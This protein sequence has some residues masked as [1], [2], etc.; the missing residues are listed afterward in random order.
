[1]HTEAR[2]T[3]WKS[4]LTYW[5][6][7]AWMWTGE[8]PTVVICLPCQAMVRLQHLNDNF[9]GKASDTQTQIEKIPG[10]SE[11]QTRE[12]SGRNELIKAFMWYRSPAKIKQTEKTWFHL[13]CPSQPGRSVLTTLDMPRSINVRA[14]FYNVLRIGIFSQEE[15]NSLHWYKCIS[16][17]Q[18]TYSGNSG[19]KVTNIPLQ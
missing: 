9:Y 14:L 5:C 13:G 15:F 18:Y 2:Y 17:K 6:G 1:M 3:T 19:R 10:R 16:R 4:H 8:K 12:I 7:Q 11:Q